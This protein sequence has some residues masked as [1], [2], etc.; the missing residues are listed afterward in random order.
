MAKPIDYLPRLSQDAK[1]LVYRLFESQIPTPEIIARLGIDWPE[2]S[3]DAEIIDKARLFW[4]SEYDKIAIQRNQAIMATI[5]K[6]GRVFDNLLISAAAEQQAGLLLDLAVVLRQRL[7]AAIAEHGEFL[8]NK[9]IQFL[10]QAAAVLSTAT[11][12]ITRTQAMLA[13][14]S[15]ELPFRASQTSG[16]KPEARNEI[17]PEFIREIEGMLGVLPYEAESETVEVDAITQP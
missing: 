3:I 5:G 16:D 11:G 14:Y 10:V 6:G 4:R 17:T 2:L 8:P 7:E 12:N 1:I 13:K 9:D 15:I